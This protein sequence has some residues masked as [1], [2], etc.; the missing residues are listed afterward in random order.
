MLLKTA[1]QQRIVG[2]MKPN[3]RLFGDLRVCLCATKPIRCALRC[4][5]FS[6]TVPLRD[7]DRRLRTIMVGARCEESLSFRSQEKEKARSDER[8]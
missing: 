6:A 4:A 2:M 1:G 8:A 7:C 3:E 5:R